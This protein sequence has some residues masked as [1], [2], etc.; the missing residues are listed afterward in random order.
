MGY[1]AYVPLGANSNM[2][3]EMSIH[4]RLSWVLV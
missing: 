3:L 4:F 1:E 2:H